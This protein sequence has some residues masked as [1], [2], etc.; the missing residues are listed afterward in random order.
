MAKTEMS[1]FLYEARTVA[2]DDGTVPHVLSS[3]LAHTLAVCRRK[4][5]PCKPRST[6]LLMGQWRR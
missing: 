2:R 4:M 6:A 3:E 1:L 5:I